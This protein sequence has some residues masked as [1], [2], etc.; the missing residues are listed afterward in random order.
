MCTIAPAQCRKRRLPRQCA[1]PTVARPQPGRGA[2]MMSAREHLLSLIDEPDP[3]D[4]PDAEVA[5]IQ[6]EA[7]RELFAERREQI[8]VLRRRAEDMG[9]DEIDVMDDVV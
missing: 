8:P 3:F 1:E 9:V 4:L 2:E 7:A 5:P 6:L